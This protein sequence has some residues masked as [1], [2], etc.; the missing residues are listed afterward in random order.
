MNIRMYYLDDTSGRRLQCHRSPHREVLH[1]Q[2]KYS[3]WQ[4]CWVICRLDDISKHMHAHILKVCMC[5]FIFLLIYSYYFF[6]MHAKF[7]QC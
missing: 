1:T 5:V 3:N 6:A 2:P 7:M 4:L